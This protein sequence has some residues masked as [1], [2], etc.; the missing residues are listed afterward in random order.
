MKAEFHK[1]FKI[2]EEL[3]EAGESAT[4]TISS[5]GG[6]S[7]IKLLL[8]SSPSSPSTGTT[9]TTLPPA[10]GRRRRHR[11]A[12]ARARRRQRAAEHQASLLVSP[13]SASP[14][15]SGE[16]IDPVGSQSCPFFI[17][18]SP[19]PTLGRR[20]VTSLGRPPPPS[21]GSLNL[22]GRPPSPVPP[23]SSSI[24]SQHNGTLSISQVQSTSYVPDTCTLGMAEVNSMSL[25]GVPGFHEDRKCDQCNVICNGEADLEFHMK[26]KHV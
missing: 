12:A 9:S 14:P 6:I 24:A 13:S 19:S 18:P 1:I 4:L 8:E 20:S 2:F 22:D 5:K 16:A 10:P 21:F 7:S 17:L 25:S 3:E 15:P 23:T 11:G 26:T